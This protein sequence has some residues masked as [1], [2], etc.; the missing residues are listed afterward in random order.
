MSTDL[1]D[2]RD[3]AAQRVE[4]FMAHCSKCENGLEKAHMQSADHGAPTNEK[5][6]MQV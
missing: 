1:Q 2:V 6:G 4:G 5:A 3:S